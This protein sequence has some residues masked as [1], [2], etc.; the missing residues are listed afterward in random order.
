[1]VVCLQQEGRRNREE[2]QLVSRYRRAL[3]FEPPV[4]KVI[5]RVAESGFKPVRLTTVLI[6]PS[7]RL[8][9]QDRNV[10]V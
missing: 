5:Q 2:A 1:M 7:H 4:A 8:H 6:L 10:L 3:N 9:R